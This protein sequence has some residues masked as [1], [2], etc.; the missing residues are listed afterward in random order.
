MPK[1]KKTG[2]NMKFKKRMGGNPPDD[3]NTTND[4]P[5]SGIF[6]NFF[7]SVSSMFKKPEQKTYQE[8]LTLDG[9]PINEGQMNQGQMNQGQMNQGQMNQGQMNQ[10]GQMNPGQM[11]PQTNQMGGCNMPGYGV[12]TNAAPFSGSTAKPHN[13]V[14]G[15]SKRRHRKHRKGSKRHHRR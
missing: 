10:M 11:N 1:T 4:K 14:G 7:S 15:R 2:R 13:W 12:A 6:G 8:P 9:K 5:K 3:Y